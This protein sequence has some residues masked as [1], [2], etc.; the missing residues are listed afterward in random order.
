MPLVRQRDDAH[1]NAI[2][3]TASEYL[4]L[5]DWA[6]RLVRDD[7]RGF[8]PADVPPILTRLG[9]A[10]EGYLRHVGGN[11]SKSHPAVLGHI[12]NIRQLAI[13]MGRGFF[14][15]LAHAQMLYQT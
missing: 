8:I 13:Q 10:P 4:E 5:V 7:K 3:F 2:G 9:L 12:D 11:V 14:K 15:G 1:P 6:G